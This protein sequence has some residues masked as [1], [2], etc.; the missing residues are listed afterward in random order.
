[1][2]DLYAEQPQHLCN[3]CYLG[4]HEKCPYDQ[5]TAAEAKAQ[6][7]VAING[8]VVTCPQYTRGCIQDGTRETC[9]GCAGYAGCWT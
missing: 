6:G 7:V 2:S 8:A 5:M 9:E 4:N 3:T 1:V